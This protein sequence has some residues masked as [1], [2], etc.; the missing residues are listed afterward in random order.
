MTYIQILITVI[1]L[2]FIAAFAGLY[3]IRKYKTGT[4]T[5]QVVY[6]L[7][8]VAISELICTYATIAEYSDFKYF[9]FVK[10]TV[11]ERNYWIHNIQLII[12][13]SFFINYFRT[14][15]RR[16]FVSQ[17]IF[18]LV[19]IFIITAVLNLI[20]TDI[21]FL[22]ISKYT[23]IT[24]SIFLLISIL[25][26]YFELL[27]SDSLLH[28]NKSLTFY[29]SVGLLIYY[30]CITPLFIYGNYY[31]SDSGDAFIKFYLYTLACANLVM[32]G[33]ITA[34]FLLCKP[35]N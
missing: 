11:F 19:R 1:S 33:T 18:Y 7:F 32:Y 29:I 22:G 27:K 15:L 16:G 28:F 24:G 34:A 12:T 13:F 35:N 6:V 17:I 3:H 31:N 9:G 20:F 26:Y 10:G 14:R 8:F 23:Y 25:V 5:K 21:Y 2:E 30:L 4:Y